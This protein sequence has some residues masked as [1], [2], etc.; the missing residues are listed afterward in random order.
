M[1]EYAYIVIIIILF[2]VI[3]CSF[4]SGDLWLN[5]KEKYENHILPGNDNISMD[6]PTGGVV[7]LED[8]DLNGVYLK[9]IYSK[10][11]GI[12]ERSEAITKIYSRQ[13]YYCYKY[14]KFITSKSIIKI[15]KTV[16]KY[17]GLSPVINI[18]AT[19]G[20]CIITNATTGSAFYCVITR[21]AFL[22]YDNKFTR[23]LL[24]A[25]RF[26]SKFL[27][28]KELLARYR[29]RDDQIF[30]TIV[31]SIKIKKN[32]VIDNWRAPKIEYSDTVINHCPAKS[33]P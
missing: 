11:G 24:V 27:P 7:D 30:K 32:G 23:I 33:L 1:K 3:G 9:Y 16:S 26:D 17:W 18:N 25:S 21:E 2:A 14:S 13:P 28:N 31:D 22:G 10:Y 6:L 19:T 15:K 20:Y 5:N 4:T 29:N 8:I 12:P